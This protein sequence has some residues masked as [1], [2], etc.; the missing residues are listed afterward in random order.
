[1]VEIITFKSAIEK[2]KDAKKRNLLLENGFS[3]AYNEKIFTYKSIL[4]KSNFDS[5]P[6]T[7]KIFDT[8]NTC[9]FEEVIKTLEKTSII[10]NDLSKKN[11]DLSKKIKEISENLKKVLI[12]TLSNTHPVSP[13]EIKNNQL[14]SCKNFLS[15]FLSDEKNPGFIYTLNYDILLYWVLIHDNDSNSHIYPN[16]GFGREEDTPEE[17]VEWLGESN[18]KQNIHYLHGSLHIFDDGLNIQKYTWIN[19]QKKIVEQIQESLTNNKFPLFVAEGTSAKKLMKIKHSAYLYHS[20]KSFSA[21]TN[22]PNNPLFIFGHSLADNDDHILKKIAKGKIKSVYISLYG[23]ANS[24]I[25]K[26]IIGKADRLKSNRDDLN[27][28]F[29][30]AKSANVWG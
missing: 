6:E 5:I 24:K 17:Y 27:I 9:D 11:D 21:I 4:D 19:T 28:T 20:Y 1:M 25:N 3:I 12:K 18:K 16:D 2:T 29:F 13:Y 22:S 7:R 23:D 26:S 10:I 8:L 14:T 15:Y 30:D